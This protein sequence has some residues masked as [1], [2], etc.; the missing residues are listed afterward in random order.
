[1]VQDHGAIDVA[2]EDGERVVSA[3][4]LVQRRPRGAEG[5]GA[6]DVARVDRRTD[7][8]RLPGDEEDW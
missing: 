7:E 1:M 4:A 3:H 6:H 5:D 2:L 8:E